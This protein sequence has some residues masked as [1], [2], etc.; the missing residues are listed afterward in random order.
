MH[1]LGLHLIASVQM[2]DV[3]NCRWSASTSIKKGQEDSKRT[4][5]DARLENSN[6]KAGKHECPGVNS[7]S[8]QAQEESNTRDF[9]SVDPFH[10][11]LCRIG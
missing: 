10:P 11:S 1:I 6:S 4:I 5:S 8:L 9:S 7:E 3:L 2:F